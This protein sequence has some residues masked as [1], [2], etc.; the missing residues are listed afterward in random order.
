[1]FV[2]LQIPPDQLALL[3]GNIRG[4]ALKP[5][6][7]GAYAANAK[8]KSTKRLFEEIVVGAESV[9][10]MP[11]GELIMLDKFGYMHRAA[12]TKGG[13]Y[14]LRHDEKLYIG[15]GR[16]LGYHIVNGGKALLVCDSLKGLLE[17][18]LKT[19]SIQVLVNT[20]PDGTPLHYA[21]DLDVASDGTVYFTASSDGTVALSPEGFYDTMRSYVLSTMRGERA[22]S[23]VRCR[24]G[25]CWYL[26]LASA[27]CLVQL[28]A[29]PHL[30]AGSWGN[31]PARFSLAPARLPRL[32]QVACK[33]VERARTAVSGGDS[34]ERYKLRC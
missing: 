24:H 1:M 9:A 15:P 23:L 21:N 22:G 8:L 5:V 27:L 6:L 30:T 16:P 25:P 2:A 19:G 33:R 4:P 13:E 20:R 3:A 29:Y 28:H 7:E 32:I 10:V 12:P 31:A 26:R 14:S 11:S 17:V 18:T 34:M